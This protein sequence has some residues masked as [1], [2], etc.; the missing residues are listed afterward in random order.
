MRPAGAGLTTASAPVARAVS[1]VAATAAGVVS[2][3][4]SHTSACAPEGGP[5]A[6]VFAP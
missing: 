6:C 1:S 4:V 5:E 2:A 3:W